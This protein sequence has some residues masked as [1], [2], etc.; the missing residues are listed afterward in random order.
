MYCFPNN[1][2]VCFF[3]LFVLDFAILGCSGALPISHLL[4]PRKRQIQWEY[5]IILTGKVARKDDQMIAQEGISI[6]Y[7]LNGLVPVFCGR[8][9]ISEVV[10]WLG[11][12]SW[13]NH[14]QVGSSKS[15]LPPPS[16]MVDTWS[17]SLPVRKLFRTPHISSALARE[18]QIQCVYST[19]VNI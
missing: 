3:I 5:S 14:E 17:L 10:L 12:H 15:S 9:F 18:R 19:I 2:L 4:W 11:N 8:C 7:E 1:I 16:V 6:I 13:T